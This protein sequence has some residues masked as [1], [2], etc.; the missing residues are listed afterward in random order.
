MSVHTLPKPVRASINRNA[1]RIALTKAYVALRDELEARAH[2][3]W[4]QAGATAETVARAL[5]LETLD[6]G[7]RSPARK[8]Q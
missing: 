8:V 4:Q 6:Y 2:D 3:L 1:Q 7:P 5:D